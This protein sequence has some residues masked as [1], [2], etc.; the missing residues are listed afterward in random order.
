MDVGKCPS[1]GSGT[2]RR[3]ATPHV[4]WRL[5]SARTQTHW[6]TRAHERRTQSVTR[7]TYTQ[8]HQTNAAAR[9]SHAYGKMNACSTHS[10]RQAGAPPAR[11]CAYWRA[12]ACE[13][14]A[15]A[16]TTSV[17]VGR[18]HIRCQSTA[19]IPNTHAGR[20]K[21]GTNTNRHDNRRTCTQTHAH[22]D[23]QTQT[24]T[25]ARTPHTAGRSRGSRPRTP[26]S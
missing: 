19:P 2:T 23:T 9:G 21:K 20:H 5:F 24:Y 25:H 3:R 10:A 18:A 4:A 17:C 6:R 26:L 15:T 12:G 11:A 13:M 22:T 7:C 8:I 1:A 16:P 14:P